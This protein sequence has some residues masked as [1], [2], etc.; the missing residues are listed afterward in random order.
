MEPTY[1]A[2]IEIGSSHIRAAV[3]MVDES[4][5]LSV[6]GV[7]EECAIDAVR[8]GG[9]QNVEEVSNRINKLKLKLENHQTI[10]PRK[11]KAVYAALGGRSTMGSP[12]QVERIYNEETEITADVLRQF[13]DEA[14]AQ[15]FSDRTVVEVLPSQFV[16]DNLESTNPRGSFGREIRA[17]FNLVTCRPLMHRNLIRAI[18][19]RQ[20]IAIKGI[21]VRQNALADLVLTSDEKKLGC[22]LVDFGAETTT[23]SIYKN[24]FLKYFVTLPVGSRCITRDVMTLGYTEE[25]AEEIKRNIGD[26]STTDPSA[27]RKHDFDGDAAEVNNYVR[28]RA[29]EIAANILEQPKYAGYSL[30]NDLPGGIILVGGGTH[31][32]GFAQLIQQPGSVKVRLGGL[33][34]SIRVAD[35]RLQRIDTLDVISILNAA[36][37]A[38]QECT[39]L[40][41]PVLSAIPS[42]EDDDDDG[43]G[44]LP[45][46]GRDKKKSKEKEK[47]GS[48]VDK[49]MG[50][51][52]K[53]FQEPDDSDE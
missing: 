29:G 10:H 33:P 37:R 2:A 51:L 14:R 31:L 38:P 20:Q 1:I 44:H 15:G 49:F 6:L 12:A 34:G 36:A 4:G 47:G 50:R 39:E 41:E 45:R 52:S 7:E 18:S 48:A 17:D 26:T 46:K 24:G 9:I 22:M 53:W 3:G 21:F 13:T 5:T 27:V 30:P 19:D 16:V 40:P 35:P 11:I 8:Y 25:K 28:A 23:V 43:P 42:G 32:R